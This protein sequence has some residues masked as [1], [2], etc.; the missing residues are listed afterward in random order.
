M[1]IKKGANGKYYFDISLGFDPIT[2]KRRRTTRSGFETKASAEAEYA[3]LKNSYFKGSL[4]YNEKT[5]FS[6]FYDTFLSWYKTQVKFTTYENRKIISEKHIRNYFGNVELKKI[7]PM[8]INNWQ[9][10]LIEDGYSREYIRGIHVFLQQIFDRAIQ[11]GALSSN[12]C[13]LAKNIKREDKKIE[14]WTVDEFQ[15]FQACN[16][17]KTL[18]DQMH[19]YAIHFFFFTG[20]RL[21]EL[22]ALTWN[23][24]QE[25]SVN[26]NKAL[27]Y[28]SMSEYSF[29]STKTKSS[30]RIIGLDNITVQYIEEWRKIQ[31]LFPKNHLN[32][33]FTDGINPIT[34]SGLSKFIDKKSK[35]AQVPRIKVHGLRHS[36][37][38]YLINLGL[39]IL[40]VSHRLGHSSTVETLKTY[41]HL[42][43]QA[44][45]DILKAINLD[46]N[47][48]VKDNE[49]PDENSTD[50]S[51][52]GVIIKFPCL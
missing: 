27:N 9:S 26:V 4:V 38:S 42:Y 34:K 23:D 15:K 14:F 11:L 17:K 45:E 24:I 30:N 5:L 8:L 52:S 33:V 46:I 7:T 49:N 6:S 47:D 50:W 43:P 48:D 1:N 3:K 41:G 19:Y 12:P 28:K 20:L 22:Q 21:G 25:N 32:L 44:S 13:T 18:R 16:T 2:G 31:E 39:D 37:A 35:E 51:K 10:S 40:K 36:H 29:M